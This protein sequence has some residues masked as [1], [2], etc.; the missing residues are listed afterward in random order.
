MQR[1]KLSAGIAKK[2]SR[3]SDANQIK[4]WSISDF[5]QDKCQCLKAMV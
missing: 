5:P 1:D 4:R 2:L 3:K